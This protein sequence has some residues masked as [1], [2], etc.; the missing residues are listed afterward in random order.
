LIEVRDEPPRKSRRKPKPRRAKAA[1]EE[2]RAEDERSSD[3]TIVVHDE[4]APGR[5]PRSGDGRV[6]L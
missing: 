5:G 6:D 4:E 2:P 3:E 1:A